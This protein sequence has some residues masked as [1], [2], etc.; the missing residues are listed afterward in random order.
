MSVSHES[1]GVGD[2]H[3]R[4]ERVQR[5]ANTTTWRRGGF[6]HWYARRRLR[7]PESVLIGRHSAALGG[8][9]LELGCGGGRITGHL[10][11]LAAKV[12]GIDIAADMVDYCRRTY[13]GATFGEGDLRDLSALETAS[14]DAI[15]AGF[16]V[17]D[18]LTDTERAHFLDEVHRLLTPGGL[19]IFSSHNLACAP[20][21]KPP[22]RNLTGNPVRFANR[23][24]RLPRSLPNHRRL[25]REQRI[26]A[27]YAILNDE[28]H[29]YSL[30]HYYIGR[31]GQQAQLAAH[32][33]EL[34][35]ALDLDGR[36][37]GPGEDAF[38]CH[39]LHYAARRL[40]DGRPQA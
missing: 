37:V 2:G 29:D 6:V 33:F 14:W 1:R 19:F 8:R 32:G 3:F 11:P 28:A 15:F 4:A 13:L 12:H 17:I 5:Q 35:E 36:P 9:V 25:A 30:L 38:G 22:A 10:M 18:V 39:E 26:G 40:D 16:N 34:L 23:L 24:L 21:I 27:G 7:P 20:L 31:D